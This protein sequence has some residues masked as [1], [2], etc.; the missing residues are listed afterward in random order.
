MLGSLVR[1]ALGAAETAIGLRTPFISGKDSLNNEFRYT[2][3][4][5]VRESIAIPA[6]L[7]VSAMG[8][9][10]NIEQCISMDLKQGGSAIYQVGA[11]HDELGGSHLSLARGAA[12]GRPPAVVPQL[13]RRIFL[14]VH[15]A[16]VEGLVLA[17]HDMSEGGLAAAAAE[18]VFAGELGATIGLEQVPR[19]DDLARLAPAELVVRLLFAESNSRF[20]CEVPHDKC[21]AFEAAMAGVPIGRIGRVA[22]EAPVEP[23]LEIF[24]TAAGAAGD[25]AET[26][27]IGLPISRLKKAWQQG[28][29]W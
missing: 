14:A 15:R 6:T 12:G 8:H 18:M 9:V 7:L 16:I 27:L 21:G 28:I 26:Q 2:S 19:A 20:L 23:R 10:A 13:A 24:A 3:T 25:R 5:G 29:A 11:T 17:C 22:S 4:N 1:A